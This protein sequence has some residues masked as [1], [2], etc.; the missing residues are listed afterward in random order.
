MIVNETIEKHIIGRLRIDNPWWSDGNIP[1]YYKNM[2]PRAYLDIFYPLVNNSKI[3]RAQILMGPRRVGKTVMIYHTIQKLMEGGVAPCNIVYISIETPIYNGVSLEQ[4]VSLAMT[5]SNNGDWM[6]KQCF[7][8]FDEVQYLKD[9]EVHLKTLVDTYRNVR[10]VASGSAAAALKK[11]SNESGAGRFSDFS[12]PPL[13]F[14]EYIQLRKQTRL[15]RESSIVW[16]GH[17]THC[18]EAAN[19]NKLNKTFID[20]INPDYPLFLVGRSRPVPL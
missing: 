17:R 2:M 15:L 16:N 11:N 8:F 3:N 4:L 5:A 9:W 1:A 14:Y 6:K 7:V 19:I 10:F 12:L 20:Y 13:T 18:F